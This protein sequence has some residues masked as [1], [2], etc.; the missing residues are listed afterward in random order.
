MYGALSYS[1]RTLC[2]QLEGKLTEHQMEILTDYG[3]EDFANRQQITVTDDKW[4]RIPYGIIDRVACR[5]HH[6]V[7][8][9]DCF[10][11]KQQ[12]LDRIPALEAKMHAEMEALKAKRQQQ[13]PSSNTPSAAA[14]AA[15]TAAEPSEPAGPQQASTSGTSATE[16]GPAA[17]A[18]K[19]CWQCSKHRSDGVKLRF[20]SRCHRALYCSTECQKAHYPTHRPQCKQWAGEAES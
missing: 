4:E 3:L 11:F 6:K 18:D 1:V 7:G 8:C 20:C 15:A 9:N 17:R 5:E 16:P 12:I 14:A 19:A 10:N 13:Q 2:L